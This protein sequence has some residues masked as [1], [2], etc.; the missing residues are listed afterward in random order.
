MDRAELSRR[1]NIKPDE[2]KL[3]TLALTLGSLTGMSGSGG[4]I[5]AI[6]EQNG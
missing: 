6:L 5:G 4:A 3:K 2:T 1:I